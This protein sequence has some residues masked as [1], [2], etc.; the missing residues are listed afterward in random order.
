MDVSNLV[1]VLREDYAKIRA[2]N[3]KTIFLVPPQGLNYVKYLIQVDRNV[4]AEKQFNED[5]IEEVSD[6]EIQ[7]QQGH[8]WV[9]TTKD[10]DEKI[11]FASNAFHSKRM[12]KLG[13]VLNTMKTTI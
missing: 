13:K 1:P 10:L 5:L 11:I 9:P 2:S 4:E 6:E 7:E 3:R 8:K 12:K